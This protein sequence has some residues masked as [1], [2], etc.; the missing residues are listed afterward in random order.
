MPSTF[1]TNL[2]IEK[3]ADGEQD[4]IWGDIVNENSD[5]LDRAVNGVLSLALSGTSSTLTTSNGTLSSGQYKLLVLTGTPSGTHTITI[6]PD[7]AQKIYY[8]RNTTAQSVIFTQGSGGNYT[9]LTGDSAIIYAN[10]AGASAAVTNIADHLAMSSVNITGGTITTASATL[11]GGTINGVTVGATTASSGRF[12][13]A[14]A[15]TLTNTAGTRGP[16]L[17]KGYVETV[18]ALTGTTPA[19]NPSNGTIQTWTL[20]ANST[21]TDSFATGESMT[22]MIDDGAAF[23]ITW[24]SVV[25]KSDAGLS[26]ALGSTGFTAVTLWKVGTTL[27]GARVGDA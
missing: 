10:G 21:P 12:T 11:T 24:P 13:S 9:L 19:L 18:F 7:T 26:P 25:W 1:T 6:A 8:V 15:D 27:Y 4:G 20:T 2:G 16:T 22:L 23:S 5:I 3:P 17:T 14:A